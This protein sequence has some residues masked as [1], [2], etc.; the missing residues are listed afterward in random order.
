[1]LITIT[2]ASMD[3]NYLLSDPELVSKTSVCKFNPLSI[4]TR[5]DHTYLFLKADVV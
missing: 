4:V 1:M 3:T 5:L 2:L